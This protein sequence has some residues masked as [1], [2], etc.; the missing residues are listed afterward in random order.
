MSKAPREYVKRFTSPGASRRSNNARV[1]RMQHDRR[2]ASE[3]LGDFLKTVNDG[4]PTDFEKRNRSD[5][6]SVKANESSVEVF[7]QRDRAKEARKRQRNK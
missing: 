3:A 6:A 7:N 4:G 5:R 2:K 1:D